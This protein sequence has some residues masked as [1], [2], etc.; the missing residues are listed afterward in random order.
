[1]FDPFRSVCAE[2]TVVVE[3]P[4]CALT[5]ACCGLPALALGGTAAPGWL[6]TALAFH[7][8]VL[9]LD[10]DEAG[11]RAS[12]QLAPRFASL[13][14]RVRRGRPLEAKDWNE[15]LMRGG[16]EAVRRAAERLGFGHGGHVVAMVLILGGRFAS[17][18][19]EDDK[20]W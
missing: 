8:V 6:A 20:A 17:P 12:A 9:A 4:I 10:A 2:R 13:G 3:A 14:S 18:I 19:Q 1:M 5:L 16:A 15:L 7:E 11:D